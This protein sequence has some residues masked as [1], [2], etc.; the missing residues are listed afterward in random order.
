MI[1]YSKINNHFMWKLTYGYR[2]YIFA[3]IIMTLIETACHVILPLII[4]YMINE[5]LQIKT[6][7][8]SIAT[9]INKVI[10]YGLILILI[11]IVALLIGTL[12]GIIL[13][14][15]SSGLEKNIRECLYY[16]ILNFSFENVDKYSVAS[17]I[18]RMTNDVTN[19]S[20][21]FNQLV[22]VLIRAPFM[23]FLSLFFSIKLS[24]SLSLMFLVAL[25]LI[26]IGFALIWY[27]TFPKFRKMFVYYDE[28][29]H[30]IQENLQGMHTIKAFVTEEKEAKTIKEKID[31]LTKI[32]IYAE[33]FIILGGILFSSVIFTSVL[34]LGGYGTQLAL[35]GI[36]KTGTLVSFSSFVWQVS[37]SLTL[38]IS[39]IGS[40][41]IALPSVKRVNEILKE[42]PMIVENN[43]GITNLE[44]NSI[45]FENV[46]LKYNNNS[47]Y[48][49]KNISFE[50]KE[51]STIGIIGK[52]G[53]GKSSLVAL[54]SKL[55]QPT[56][57]TIK[58]G[59]IDINNY[60][61][62]VLRDSITTV[63]Q[64]NNLFSGSIR[65]NMQWANPNVSDQEIFQALKQAGIYD[66]VNSLEQ[67]LDFKVTQ[68]GNNLSGGQK[69]RL[70]IARALIKKPK[71]L[72]LDDS[73]SAVDMKTEFLIQQS[74]KFEIK[75]CTKIIIAQRVSSIVHADLIIVLDKGKIIAQGTHEK[76]LKTSD[77][78][79][80]LNQSRLN[81][82]AIDEIIN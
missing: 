69:Q 35:N 74:L 66:F 37:G 21:A 60:N 26:V 76:L 29:N 7:N 50:I 77:F 9:D 39:V 17:L 2:R 73:T 48:S 57:G 14:K 36:I 51:N 72:I 25:P 82:G 20:N 55:Y 79:K 30:K 41:M 54:I 24:P 13:A 47:N 1:N 11:A 42:K 71:I 16:K 46:S 10:F 27:K 32:N 70:C 61:T 81:Q 15:A 8:N 68:N 38:L 23:L 6:S 56:S 62:F 28:L 40:S 45:V 3:T 31:K 75:N 44:K 12:N 78:Y 67:K 5:G 22:K 53:S 58:I 49:L 19:I 34:F 65:S 64:K 43:F 52:T 4:G 33:R 18:N 59:N 63:L 80:V